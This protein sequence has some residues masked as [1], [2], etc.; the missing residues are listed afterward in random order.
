M[1]E[2]EYEIVKVERKDG[3][4]V[5]EAGSKIAYKNYYIHFKRSDSPLVMRAK[6]DKVFNDYVE[7]DYAAE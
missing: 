4:F 5:T 2:Q 1:E 6:V 3:E 7:G